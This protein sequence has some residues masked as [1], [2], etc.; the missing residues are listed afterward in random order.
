[1]FWFQLETKVVTLE[2]SNVVVKLPPD[3]LILLP[4][5]QFL[6]PDVTYGV[7]VL[8][9]PFSRLNDIFN[10]D[11]PMLTTTMTTLEPLL[12]AVTYA[13]VVELNEE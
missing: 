8:T 10:E 3:T 4:W 13:F 6:V 9:A 7:N 11:E 5:V 2:A 12:Y 1:M